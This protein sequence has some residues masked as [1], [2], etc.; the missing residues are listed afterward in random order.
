M[1]VSMILVPV[2]I[3]A[4]SAWHASRT[5]EDEAGQLVCNVSTR[6]RD[7]TLLRQALTDTSA[8]VTEDGTSLLA[9]WVGVEAR[10]TR[11]DNDIWSAHLTGDIDESQAVSIIAAIDQAY[12]LRVQTEVLNR[13]RS[14]AGLAGMTIETEKKNDDQSVT[15]VLAV[16]EVTA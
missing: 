10:F 6:M 8:A 9:T 2:A 14:R 7:A 4:A 11:D 15:M 12:G 1:S 5:E 3:A 13:L 16:Q